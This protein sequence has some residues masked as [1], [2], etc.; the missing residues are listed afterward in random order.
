MFTHAHATELGKAFFN[1]FTGEG[2]APISAII[3]KVFLF[4]LV[5]LILYYF[6]STIS[7]IFYALLLIVLL[8]VICFFMVVLLG[9]PAASMLYLNVLTL[10]LKRG[11]WIIEC[12]Y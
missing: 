2:V 11:I 4:V 1:I 5:V 10:L 6:I 8:I 7:R 3:G 12:F 9:D